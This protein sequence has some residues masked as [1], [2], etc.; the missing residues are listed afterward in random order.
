MW[1]IARYVIVF[2]GM[3]LVIGCAARPVSLPGATGLLSQGNVLT[4][5]KFNKQWDIIINEHLNALPDTPEAKLACFHKVL[6]RGLGA[7]LNDR[8]SHYFSKEEMAATYEEIHGSYTG[9]GLNLDD[10]HTYIEIASI[11]KNSPAERSDKF[12]VGDV[13]VEVNGEDISTQ[14]LKA[15]VLKIRGSA[16]TDVAIRVKRKGKKLDA[17]KLVREDISV[18]SVHAF[19]IDED[20]TYIRID[21]FNKLTPG[22]LVGEMALRL[23]FQLPSGEWFLDVNAKRFIYDLRGNPGGMLEA[24]GM[25]SYLFADN[26]DDIIITEQSRKERKILRARDFVADDISVPVGLFKSVKSVLIINNRSASAAEIF[27]DFLH[28]ATGAERV[29]KKSYGKGSIQQIFP[30]ED[31]DGLLLTI[32]EYFVGNKKV[33]IDKIGIQ[34]EYEVD[35]PKFDNHNNS[36]GI[37]IDLKKDL[38]LKK[39][40]ELLRRP[41]MLRMSKLK[42]GSCSLF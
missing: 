35:N 19:D 40:I 8:F 3:I 39:A 32:A 22:E 13:L 37:R 42:R 7:C 12:Q 20:I 5:E 11:T 36:T 14:S 24:V 1:H 25:M 16:G 15:I 18:R 30:L 34:P 23:L 4:L 27:A 28:Q 6:A 9:V 17:I 41:H 38:Q 31:E 21:Y 2:L 29:G 10:A 26:G 33:R